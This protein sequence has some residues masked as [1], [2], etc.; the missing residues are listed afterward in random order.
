MLNEFTKAVFVKIFPL[1]FL[2]VLLSILGTVFKLFFLP[3][4]KGWLGEASI[5]FLVRRMLDQNVYHLIPDVMLPTSDGTTQ[6]D[7]VIV[8]HYGIF[9]LET[10][11]YKGW[12]Y[13]N[14]N[15]PQWTQ[16]IYKRKERGGGGNGGRRCCYASFSGNSRRRTSSISTS[17]AA[18]RF[19]EIRSSF[20]TT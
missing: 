16:V 6:I 11:N 17:L 20:E 13:G 12:I 3:K 7:H 14:E 15:D 18:A 5:N 2:F 9:V 1:I 8:S 19:D 10:K 4:I